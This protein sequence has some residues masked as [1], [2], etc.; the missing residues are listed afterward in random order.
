MPNYTVTSPIFHDGQ[1]YPV[2]AQLTLDADIAASVAHCLTPGD[3]P[4]PPPVPPAPVNL[5]TATEEALTALP[6]IGRTIAAKLIKARPL[7]TLEDAQ[8]AAGLKDPQWA[9]LINVITL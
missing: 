2:G 4:V 8:A 7:H 1:T 9:D 5:N 3:A 6:H